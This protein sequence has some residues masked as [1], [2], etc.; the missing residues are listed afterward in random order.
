MGLKCSRCQFVTSVV[1]PVFPFNCLGCCKSQIIIFGWLQ[2]FGVM[3]DLVFW[4]SVLREHSGWCIPHLTCFPRREIVWRAAEIMTRPIAGAN[5]RQSCWHWFVEDHLVGTCL[6][7]LQPRIQIEI[8]GSSRRPRS[9]MK[10]SSRNAIRAPK[11]GKNSLTRIGFDTNTK[12]RAN[13]H[14]DVP[15]YGHRS[16]ESELNNTKERAQAFND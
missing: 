15:I 11:I 8:S 14:F 13:T 4:S 7:Y 2:A 9:S 3:G 1:F 12:Q 5:K 16:H 10:R 6:L